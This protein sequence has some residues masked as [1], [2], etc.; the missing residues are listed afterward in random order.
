MMMRRDSAGLLESR[1][2]SPQAPTK[3][4][5]KNLACFR[6]IQLWI[7]GG[8]VLAMVLLVSSISTYR[9][10]SRALILDHL[11]RELRSEA[12]QLEEQA[13]EG[14][15]QTNRELELI[16]K[17]ALN[18]AAGRIAW[19]QVQNGDGVTISGTDPP[20]V[21][22]FST[23]EIR[24]HFRGRQPLFKTIKSGRGTLLVER[25]PF[26]FS[27]RLPQRKAM[28]SRSGPPN[29]IEIAEFWEDSNVALTPVRWHLFIN[30]SG[31]LLLLFALA[32]QCGALPSAA[33]QTRQARPAG[34]AANRWAG[35]R[36]LTR[37][38]I[39]AGFGAVGI[40]RLPDS[41]L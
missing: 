16:I 31:A 21:Q 18:G 29:S 20:D 39:R 1:V 19:I 26:R 12:A 27:T 13:R 10:V 4:A 11:R 8:I 40:R 6:W 24:T 38:A 7:C 17:K 35:P 28:N 14:S 3:E 33:D 36:T 5:G 25:L 15:V 34:T 2:L 37:R 30:S 41:L 23:E 9:A 32:H 22:V